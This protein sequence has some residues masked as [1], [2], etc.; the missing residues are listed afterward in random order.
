MLCPPIVCILVKRW[1]I[2]K[3]I[4]K[5]ICTTSGSDTSAMKKN[6]EQKDFPSTKV[7][8]SI[9]SEQ[10]YGEMVL[11]KGT[12]AVAEKIRPTAGG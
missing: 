12:D 3:K 9:E 1:K 11:E 8:S 5:G 6:E 2:K 4:N 7:V 10:V